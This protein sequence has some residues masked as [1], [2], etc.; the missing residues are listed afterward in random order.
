[1]LPAPWE[2]CYD[3]S[4]GYYYYWNK[5]TNEVQ[6]YPP[7]VTVPPPPPPPP[8]PT[9]LEEKEVTIDSPLPVVEK[10]ENDEN[11]GPETEDLCQ[12]DKESPGN[13]LEKEDAEDNEISVTVKVETDCQDSVHE[14]EESPDNDK[15]NEGENIIEREEENDEMSTVDREKEKDK[16]L[17]NQIKEKIRRKKEEK[18]MKEKEELSALKQQQQKEDMLREKLIQKKKERE[19]KKESPPR[20]AKSLKHEKSPIADKK[21]VDIRSKS[22]EEDQD[23]KDEGENDVQV[24]NES[25]TEEDFS[26]DMFAEEINNSPKDVLGEKGEGQKSQE[27][28]ELPETK[29]MVKELET[30]AEDMETATESPLEN[31]EVKGSWRIVDSV[32][33]EDDDEEEDDEV[34]DESES[35]NN[36]SSDSEGSEKSAE[37][38]EDYANMLLEGKIFFSYFFLPS[39]K[40]KILIMF[41]ALNK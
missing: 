26:L 38:M 15:K 17:M 4:T 21:I 5:T 29:V 24:L 2:A 41:G 28:H 18:L 23:D 11:I 9:E 30:K 12:E 8:P 37:E 14:K 20:V 31:K 13:D 32:Y 39:I 33:D 6:W 35:E 40:I 16:E 3:E 25:K 10:Q 7:T 27:H 1:M 34:K 19:E 22:S 36:S